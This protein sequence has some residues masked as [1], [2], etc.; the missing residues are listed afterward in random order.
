MSLLEQ[1]TPN[2]PLDLEGFRPLRGRVVIRET[3]HDSDIL[4]TP[5][6]NPRERKSHRGA[7]L[8][9]GPRARTMKGVEVAHGYEVGDEV[10]FIHAH[11]EKPRSFPDG[12][13]VVS[14]EEVIGVVEA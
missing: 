5:E 13:V 10:Y 11:L 2:P 4:W 1:I 12:V 14:Q 6:G 9:I 3:K 7:V 8:A